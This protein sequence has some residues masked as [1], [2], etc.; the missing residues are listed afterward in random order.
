VGKVTYLVHRA[1]EQLK[2][3][4]LPILALAAAV[5]A[6]LAVVAPALLGPWSTQWFTYDRHFKLIQIDAGPDDKQCSDA[7]RPI[8]VQVTNGSS[9][10]VAELSFYL[11]AHRAGQDLDVSNGGVW[12]GDAIA[13]EATL[14]FCTP[15]VLIEDAAGDDPRHFFWTARLSWVRFAD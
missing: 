7:A 11:N 13:P 15:A 10:T 3:W 9:K 6:S 5:A 12:K 2:R 14:K 4:R 8:R 1:A